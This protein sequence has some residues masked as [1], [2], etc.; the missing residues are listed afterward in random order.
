MKFRWTEEAAGDLET[1]ANYLFERTPGR[2]AD[3]FREVYQAPEAL[4]TFP[5]RADRQ[6]PGT[7]EFVLPTLP[8]VVVYQVSDNVINIV[9]ILH[10]AQNWPYRNRRNRAGGVASDLARRLMALPSGPSGV[11]RLGVAT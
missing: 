6:K 2:A 4:L 8:Y 9:R 10:V 5:Y 11:T 1:I 7:R 3:I